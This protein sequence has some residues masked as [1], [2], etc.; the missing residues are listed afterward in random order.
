LT[1]EKKY[2]KLKQEQNKFLIGEK[3][4]LGLSL[5][6]QLEQK[7]L[8]THRLLLKQEVAQAKI[9]PD[10]ACP[11]CKRKHSDEEL[12]EGW[13]DDPYDFTT[14]CK[15]CEHRFIAILDVEG[16]STKVP[17]GS[18]HYLCPDQLHTALE[19]LLEYTKRRNLGTKFLLDNRPDLF[20]NMIRHNGTYELGLKSF[21]KWK[22]KK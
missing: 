9:E 1:K 22:K 11:K 14:Q 18:F 6:L 16:D 4:P 5:S 13:N 12:R 10:T 21:K 17:V 15:N 19:D 7:Q 3:M 20:W 8:L 2:P